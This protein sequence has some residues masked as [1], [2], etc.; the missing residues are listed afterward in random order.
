MPTAWHWR[1]SGE[2]ADLKTFDPR[3]VAAITSF[4]AVYIGSAV[5]FSFQAYPY[6]VF[7][8]A[9]QLAADSTLRAQLLRKT[10]VA[11]AF[12]CACVDNLVQG[13]F[14]FVPFFYG[15]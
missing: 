6:A 11:H 5:H 13:A 7:A 14:F 9:R 4:M 12:G 10:T 15:V 2:P 8:A 1:K 3:R